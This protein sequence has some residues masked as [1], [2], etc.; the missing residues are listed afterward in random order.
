MK[1]TKMIA[2]FITLLAVSG[3]FADRYR[4]GRYW[5]DGRYYD[6]YYRDGIVRDTGHAVG[7]ALGGIFGG[8]SARRDAADARDDAAEARRDAEAARREAERARNSR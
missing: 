5:T 2:M 7:D 6:G 8:G 1:N 4:D 3:L